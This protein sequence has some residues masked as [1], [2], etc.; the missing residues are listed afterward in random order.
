MK[1]YI[2]LVFMLLMVM[3]TILW[4]TKDMN[5]DVWDCTVHWYGNNG[6]SITICPDSIKNN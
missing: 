2:L 1:K 5:W 4:L 3:F 6:K